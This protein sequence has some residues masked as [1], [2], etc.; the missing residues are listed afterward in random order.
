M[1]NH[2]ER[3]AQNRL[4]S[5]GLG[6]EGSKVQ[7]LMISLQGNNLEVTLVRQMATAASRLN[8]GA[9]SPQGAKINE[10]CTKQFN[11]R[12]RLYALLWQ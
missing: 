9:E 11:D 10:H 6:S 7:I 12:E 5:R 1:D 2:Y 4:V 3:V 8:A